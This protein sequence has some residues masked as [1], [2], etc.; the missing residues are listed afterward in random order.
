MIYQK[1]R[2]EELGIT[3]NVDVDIDEFYCTCPECGKEVHLDDVMIKH[4]INEN[5]LDFI[6]TDFFCDECVK[7]RLLKDE[8]KYRKEIML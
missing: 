4:I 2:I 6:G 1:I 8:K 5:G 3:V 7:E